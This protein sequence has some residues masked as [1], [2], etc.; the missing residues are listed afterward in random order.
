MIVE[1]LT[2]LTILSLLSTIQELIHWLIPEVI[3]ASISKSDYD[4]GISMALPQ[5]WDK[6]TTL[7]LQASPPLTCLLL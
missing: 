7:C 3:R 1:V 2:V 6:D 4:D 5:S